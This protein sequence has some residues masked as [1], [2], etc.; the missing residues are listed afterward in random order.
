M[1]SPWIDTALRA[2]DD[3]KGTNTTLISVGEVI[4][5]TDYFLI[6]SG[7]TGRQV[8]AIVEEIEHLI[9]EESGPSPKRIEGNQDYKWV[10]MDYG[11]FVVHV[12]DAKEHEYYQ[13]DKLWSD[14][15]FERIG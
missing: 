2:I 7:N 8:R 5:V 13:L 3:K 15:P 14:L 9:K 1:R 4:A 6:T 12:F 11:D 10:L